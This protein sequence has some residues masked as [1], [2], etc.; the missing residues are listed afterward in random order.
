MLLA[1]IGGVVRSSQYISVPGVITL[2]AVRDRKHNQLVVFCLLPSTNG[3]APP[4]QRLGPL[5]FLRG[6]TPDHESQRMPVER[7]STLRLQDSE[8]LVDT[9]A[10][11]TQVPFVEFPRWR[12]F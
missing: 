6:D 12:Q 1:S 3:T 2:S 8:F 10:S 7:A 4:L 11:N 9:A 5:P